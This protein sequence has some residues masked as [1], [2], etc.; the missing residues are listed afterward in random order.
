MDIRCRK[1]N[2]RY[3]DKL[4]CRANQIP[5][6]KKLICESYSFKEGSGEDISRKIF[7]SDNPPQVSPYLHNKKVNL[8]CEAK[9]LFNNNGKCIANGITINDCPNPKCI[10]H[11]KP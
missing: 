10:T 1:T 11:M 8:T 4:T 3:N 2:C 9:C 7:S 6:S 5:I